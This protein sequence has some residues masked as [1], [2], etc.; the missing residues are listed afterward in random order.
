VRSRAK[1]ENAKRRVVKTATVIV[2]VEYILMISF[3]STYD[4]VQLKSLT[5]HNFLKD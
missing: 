1:A 4:A 2:V 3:Q 5:R